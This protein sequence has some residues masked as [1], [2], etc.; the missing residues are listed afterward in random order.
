[1]LDNKA[2]GFGVFKNK[3]KEVR[4]NYI[5]KIYKGYWIDNK[6]Q[7]NGTEIRKNGIKYEG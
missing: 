1:M 5:F 7:G 6:L 3:N 2:N 4:G